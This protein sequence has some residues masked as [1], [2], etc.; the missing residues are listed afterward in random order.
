MKS[1]FIG[2]MTPGDKV[3]DLFAVR[4][5]DLREYSGGK[6]ISLEL[7]DRTGRMNGVIWNGPSDL[8]KALI[9]GRIFRVAGTVSTYKGKSQ[10]TI[11]TVS[12]AGEFDAGDFL[13]VG[14]ISPDRLE[15][16]LDSAIREISD[17]HYSKLLESVFGDKKIRQR[18]LGGV[19][20]KLW[21]HNYVGGLA[22]HSLAIFDLCLDF[23]SLY[24]ELDRDLLL[25]GA[26]LHDIGKIET[27]SLE[28]A[29]DYTD[30]GRLLGHIVIGDRIVREASGKIDDFPPEKELLIR[31]LI[32]SHQGSPEQSSPVPPM[33]AEGMALYIADLLDSKLAAMRRIRDR[34][35]RSGVR[36]S[37]FVKLLDRHIYFGDSGEDNEQEDI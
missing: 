17:V 24:E 20:G 35:K 15:K 8:I 26:L 14:E 5:V 18:F 12:P 1:S 28:G 2:S 3:D 36:W 6:M 33:T 27:Y 9:P 7:V 19:A 4:S 37:N 29:I 22:E 13:P 23:S 25:T 10:L 32:L 34:E 16:S 30:T 31:H 11:D 21:H